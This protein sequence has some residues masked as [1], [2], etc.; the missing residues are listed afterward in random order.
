MVGASCAAGTDAFGVGA[1]FDIGAA[2]TAAAA[3]NL[4]RGV[5]VIGEVSAEGTAVG[6]SDGRV[7]VALG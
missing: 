1:A 7:I 2:E 3:A 5:K 6:T 4:G